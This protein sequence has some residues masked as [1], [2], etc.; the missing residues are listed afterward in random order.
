MNDTDTAVICVTLDETNSQLVKESIKGDLRDLSEI[1]S[2]GLSQIDDIKK[3]YKIKE[4]E[5]KVGTL[6]EAVV[7]RMSSKEIMT[8]Q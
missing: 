4:E 8:F 1:H 5:L 6:L 2:S 7:N 3:I